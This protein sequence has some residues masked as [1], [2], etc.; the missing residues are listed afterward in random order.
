MKGE[1]KG[2]LDEDDIQTFF[3]KKFGT[4]P[5]TL[6]ELDAKKQVPF[7][8]WYK[9]GKDHPFNYAHMDKIKPGNVFD[10]NTIANKWITWF[11]TTPKQQNPFLNPGIS[12]ADKTLYAGQNAFLFDERE[13]FVYFLSATPFQNPDFRRV[14]MLRRAPIL[15]PIYNVIASPIFFPSLQDTECYG[16]VEKDL[17]GLIDK[18]VDATFDGTHFYGCC[19]LRNEPLTINNIPIDNVYGIPEDRLKEVNSSISVYHGGLYLLI[20]EDKFTPGDH[21]LT[22]RAHS[23]NYEIDAKILITT[24]A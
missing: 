23:V 3:E 11:S 10:C 8:Y 19:V 13:T 15:V 12:S 18:E 1:D 16:Y 24:L 5:T 17:E 20:K 7:Y 21:L 9:S 6:Q 14:I 2:F 4:M 22:F